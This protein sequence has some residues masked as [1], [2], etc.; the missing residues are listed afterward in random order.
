MAKG[1]LGNMRAHLIQY[2]P[3]PGAGIHLSGAGST[4]WKYLASHRDDIGQ[5]GGV[6]I[7]DMGS[8]M[9]CQGNGGIRNVKYR[10]NFSGMVTK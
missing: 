10:Y 1:I 3:E 7:V 9:M 8:L 6:N 5:S 2:L 4:E